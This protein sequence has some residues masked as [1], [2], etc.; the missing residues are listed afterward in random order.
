M[1]T[2]ELRNKLV[3]IIN[4]SDDRF[5]RMVNALHKSYIEKND[6]DFFSEL[7][8]EIQELLLESRE[9]ARQG[10]TRDHRDVMDDF[11][12]KYNIPS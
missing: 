9:Q 6:S 10:N 3:E 5:L 7:P 2:L 1:G 4:S 8:L 12:R 11:R